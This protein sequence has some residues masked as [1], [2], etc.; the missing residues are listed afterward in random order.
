VAQSLRLYDVVG[1]VLRLEAPCEAALLDCCFQSDESV[2]FSAASDGSV[3]RFFFF[4]FFF[5]F[6]CLIINSRIN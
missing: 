1:S 5:N 4:F 2:A 3:R 6:K